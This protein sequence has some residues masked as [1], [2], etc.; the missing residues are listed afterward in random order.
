[1]PGKRL[2]IRMGYLTSSEDL[3]ADVDAVKTLLLRQ[4]D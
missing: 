2:T 1:M 3:P 4:L